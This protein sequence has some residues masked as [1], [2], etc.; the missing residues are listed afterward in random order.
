MAD[1]PVKPYEY[2]PF[3]ILPREADKTCNA[4]VRLQDGTESYCQIETDT[5][6]RCVAHNPDKRRKLKEAS[7]SVAERLEKRAA[8]LRQDPRNVYELDDEIIKLG[9]LIDILEADHP[10]INA[11]IIRR[12][13]ETK[14]KL[15]VARV[16]IELKLQMAVP[17]K[18][19]YDEA[20]K[21]FEKH[22][23][24]ANSRVI[25]VT[26]FAAWLDR[27]MTSTS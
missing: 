3:V 5:R 8:E 16:N 19:V 17:K 15:I 13:K 12:L 14:Q 11:E 24:D 9:A 26:E 6:E 22:I 23:V 7:E 18:M 1:T 2:Q 27:A 20:I 25:A 4:R 21:L 10:V